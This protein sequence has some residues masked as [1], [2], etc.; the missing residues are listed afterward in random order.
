MDYSSSL[1]PIDPQVLRNNQYVPALGYLDKVKEMIEKSIDGTLSDVEFAMF[2]TLD[3]AELKKYEEAKELSI[4]L[5]KQ[6]LTK[7]KFKNWNIHKTDKDK[8]DKPVTDEGK[9]ERAEHIAKILSDNKLWHA[10][11]RF[12]GIEKIKNE[13]KLE[14]EDYSEKKDLRNSILTYNNLLTEFY[15]KNN[16][17]ILFHTKKQKELQ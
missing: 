3:L 6:W 1:G 7:Y 5:L 8:K 4:D 9:K 15:A 11:D 13:L 14:I 2:Q 10:H 17:Q 12:I 16:K